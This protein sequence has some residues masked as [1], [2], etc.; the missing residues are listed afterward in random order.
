M[1]KAPL[2]NALTFTDV[3]ES[4]WF[5]DAVKWAAKE[6]IV[7]GETFSPNSPCTRAQTLTFLWRAKGMPAPTKQ[8]CPLTDV[9]EGA[10]YYEPVLWAF[11]KGLLSASDDGQFHAEDPV[12]R[13][14]V[15]TFLY[16]AEGSPQPC[17]ATPYS[18]VQDTDWFAPQAIWAYETGIVA[19]ND[20]KTFSPND[21][22]NRAQYVNFLFRCYGN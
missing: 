14:Q 17:S 6:G 1:N 7:S 16:R 21:P 18:D 9:T 20:A 13:A 22:C 2:P 3:Q 15:V 19:L 4:D 8:D 11:E 5:Y 10:Y 12:T